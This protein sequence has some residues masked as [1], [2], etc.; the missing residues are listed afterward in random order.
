MILI[1]TD[2]FKLDLRGYRKAWYFDYDLRDVFL[3]YQTV[4]RLPLL[5]HKTRVMLSNLMP[6]DSKGMVRL[7]KITN[8]K[9]IL[10]SGASFLVPCASFRFLRMD[11]LNCFGP[12]FLVKIPDEEEPRI[13]ALFIKDSISLYN[14]GTET[15]GHYLW[16]AL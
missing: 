3:Q 10:F 15:F 11:I 7:Y 13:F 1:E 6:P 5:D 2:T 12:W 16:Q 14:L 9:I 8:K 4:S